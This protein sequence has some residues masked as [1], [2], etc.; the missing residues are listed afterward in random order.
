VSRTC[1][2]HEKRRI[3]CKILIVKPNSKDRFECVAVD[4]MTGIKLVL[5]KQSEVLAAGWVQRRGL[6][7]NT[8]NVY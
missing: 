5:K 2:T 3:S 1:R 8:M 7:I 4:G 6:G